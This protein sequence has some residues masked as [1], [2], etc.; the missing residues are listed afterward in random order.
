MPWSCAWPGPSLPAANGGLHLD[1]AESAWRDL[2]QAEALQT[3]ERGVDRLRQTLNRLAV[4]EVRATLQT[5]DLRRAEETVARYRGR[6]VTAAEL[7]VLEE[8]IKT[9]LSSRELA[10]RGEFA[11]A[12]ETFERVRK[13]LPAPLHLLE[14]F[15]AELEQRQQTCDRLLVLLTEVCALGRWPE[16]VDLAGQVLVVAPNHPEAR[17]CAPRPGRPSSQ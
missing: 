14:Q 2:L 13:L 3:G 9:W 8:A 12:R 4:A 10:D 15:R 5:G 1:D 7:G 11:A 16:A 17:R 6:G